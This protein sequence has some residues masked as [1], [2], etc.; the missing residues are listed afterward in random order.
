[1]GEKVMTKAE[2]EDLI[3]LVKQ[4]EA[5]ANQKPILTPSSEI[6]PEPIAW[7]W[8]HWLARG[9]VHLLAGQPGVGKST[10]AYK[11]AATISTGGSFPDGS[12]ADAGNVVIWSGDDSAKHTIV[13]KLDLFDWLPFRPFTAD[14]MAVLSYAG[15]GVPSIGK[16]PRSAR[17][18]VASGHVAIEANR[19]RLENAGRE[20]LDRL[21]RE[22][23]PQ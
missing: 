9:M 3:R 6:E 11:L 4:H 15:L 20:L 12:R 14:H 16:I 23:K 5:R 10:L 13:P 2:R 18:L 21:M 1:M 19:Y 22:G 8:R 7:L 17:E